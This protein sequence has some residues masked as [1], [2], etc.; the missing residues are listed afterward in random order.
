M[1]TWLV[2]ELGGI[3]AL[4]LCELPEPAPPG[5][6]EVSVQ[7]LATAINYPDLLMLS[8]GYQ[9][10]P[11]LP[12][13]PGMEGVGRVTATGAGVSETLLGSRVLVGSRTGLL[14][15]RVTLTADAVRPVPGAMS[16]AEA[17][18]FTVGALTAWVGL[19]ARGRLRPGEE[20][21]VLGASGGMGLMAIAT[22]LALK[23]RVTAVTSAAAKESALRAAGAADV[24]V[25]DRAAPDLSVLRERM[26]VVFDPVGGPLVRPAIS[27]LRWRGRYL[28]IGFVGGP[29]V[30]VPTNLAL[31]KGI[32][33]LG[34]R[35]GESGRR[36]PQAGL[37]YRQ[38]IDRLAAS[39]KLRA[40]VQEEVE[41][42]DAPRI[43]RDMEAGRLI[44]KAVVRIGQ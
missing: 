5:P 36:D 13:T 29:P 27:T 35:A 32:E 31:L 16:D 3:G 19:H 24:V 7:M 11:D 44:G 22:G 28:V 20:L 23:A 39:G 21:L 2:R 15:E 6:G 1:K 40:I 10:R 4:Q 42:A 26:D 12:F 34:V 41:M 43:F 18:G 8:G 30:A 37:R 38:E 14:A 9:H 17:A 25:V 33:I